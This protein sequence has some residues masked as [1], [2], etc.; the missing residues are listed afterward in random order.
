ME[1]IEGSIREGE[2]VVNEDMSPKA[3][4]AVRDVVD[5]ANLR[6]DVLI[7]EQ[8][9]TNK[10]LHHLTTQA[11]T[12]I[13]ALEHVS[14]NTCGVLNEAHQQTELLTGI[15]ADTADLL[16][17]TRS[18]NPAGAV[19]LDKEKELRRDIARCCPP[20]VEC[21]ACKYVPC[22]APQPLEPPQQS[23]GGYVSI[24]L[25]E[26]A[27]SVWD[28]R[29]TTG[30]QLQLV[31]VGSVDA[32]HLR[33]TRIEVE[34]GTYDGPMTLPFVLGDL[35]AAEDIRFDAV[36]K[37]ATIDGSP[38]VL[39]VEGEFG[40]GISRSNFR[41]S[42][43][44]S[45]SVALPGPFSSV[46]SQAEKQ[47][48]NTA[49]YP[50]VSTAPPD[51]R[52]GPNAET[53]IFLPIGPP[54]Q[55]FPPTPAGTNVNTTPGGAVQIPVNTTM[56]SA[57]V[58]PD[59][60]AAAAAADGVVLAT[61]NTGISFS[62]DGGRNFT[63]IPLLSPQPGNPARTTF[64]PQSDGGLC[65]DQV[66]V[67]I[68]NRN[69]FVWLLQYNP[70]KF[71]SANCPPQP[72]PAPPPTFAISQ[73]SRLR[74][75]W[76]TPTAIATDFWNA[77]SY[78]DLTGTGLGTT[79]SEWLDY[80]DLAWSDT[81]LYVG[82][83]HGFPIPGKVYPGRRIVARLSL[84]N[85]VDPAATAVGY[86][87]S[88]LTGANALNKSHFVQGAP[89]R[90]V[91]GALQDSSTLRVFTWKD[92]D[93]APVSATVGISQI[94]QGNAYT[95]TAPAP[96]N[97]D[98]IA[99][100]FP[101]NITGAA[102]RSVLTGLGGPTRHEYLFAF[103]AGVNAAGGR[104][105]AYVRLETLALD[106]DTYSV[107]AEYDVWNPNYA[108]AMAALGS[109]GNE[110]GI[111]LAVGGGTLGYPQF[112][113]GYKDDFEVF[114]VTNSNATQTS[115]FGDYVCNR[116]IPGGLFAAE[117]YDVVLNPVPPGGIT[118]NMR[119]VQYGRPPSTPIH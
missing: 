109:D 92:E 101:G 20:E 32:A 27:V 66:V 106:G 90:M 84:A 78:L 98:W 33:V 68:P 91:L 100:S 25:Q 70:I 103:D 97:S 17:L 111:T 118:A 108:Y 76:A 18:V 85:M 62:T 65:C 30:A 10:A 16:D 49:T 94:Q 83:D 53:P 61:Y 96:D 110:I 34:R 77:W 31:N 95:S 104:P 5:K 86:E 69:L 114:Q 44:I 41:T 48:P 24:V 75:A 29:V 22:L 82:V 46:P 99:V 79:N 4:D 50:P 60:N 37:L 115:R 116:L 57:G 15:R 40:A 13:C 119:F 74:V 93:P 105:Q 47:N 117:V 107:F 6:L 11:D 67:Y 45:P 81:F 3:M 21:P 55:L 102:Y 52:F 56:R 72:P 2:K 63:D 19:Q 80:P 7:G 12:I 73:T 26:T 39:T 58:P 89:G 23:P 64:F 28:D 87:L 71:C 59:P 51:M 54:R 113:V 38:R 112:A 8:S 9:Y 1:K 14:R 35:K 36:L 42:L 88:E 43:T